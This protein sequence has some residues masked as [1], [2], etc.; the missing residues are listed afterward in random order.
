VLILGFGWSWWTG[1]IEHA[2]ASDVAI[3][4]CCIMLVPAFML[5]MVLRGAR[6]AAA[7]LG[8]IELDDNGVRWLHSHGTIGFDVA[9]SEV[10]RATFDPQ[11]A[12]VVLNRRSGA[13]IANTRLGVPSDEREHLN[14]RS[15]SALGR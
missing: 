6:E 14:L 11:N 13:A 5:Q 9:W 3:L 7:T 8:K 12:M 1:R 4:V 2:D 10:D 15:S